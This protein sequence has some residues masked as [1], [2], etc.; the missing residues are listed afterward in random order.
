EVAVAARL[1]QPGRVQVILEGTYLG[2]PFVQEAIID[3]NGFGELAARGWAEVAVNELLALNDPTLESLVTAYCQQFGIASRVASFLVLENQADYKRLNL[4]EERGRVLP[5][6]I[7]EFLQ[8]AWQK[9][10]QVSTA[11]EALLSFLAR[12]GKQAKL[13]EGPS[14]AEAKRVLGLLAESD[15]E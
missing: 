4:Q 7:A 10:S 12:V 8:K 11:K 14:G 15:F 9:L 5:G 3:A 13:L 2:K 6:D 1:N